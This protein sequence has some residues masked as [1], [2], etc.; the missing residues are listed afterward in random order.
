ME[1]PEGGVLVEDKFRSRRAIRTGEKELGRDEGEH[2]RFP[3]SR[4]S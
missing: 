4:I 2:E 1:N 3:K